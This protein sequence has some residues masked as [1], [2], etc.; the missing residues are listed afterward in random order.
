[1]RIMTTPIE[2]DDESLVAFLDGELPAPE[3]SVI[4][5]ALESDASL[6]NRVRTLRN[7]WDLLGELP[8]VQ[9][10]PVL[11]QSTIEMVALAVDKESR[12]WISWL[13]VQRW[14]ILGLAAGSAGR[15]ER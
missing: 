9:P 6:Q 1:M 2:F 3:A 4:E 15:S 8:D 5:S 12:S 7:T 13:A 10:N 14:R 11:A